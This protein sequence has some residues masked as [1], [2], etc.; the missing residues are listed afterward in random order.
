MIA[1]ARSYIHFTTPPASGH[2]DHQVLFWAVGS[3]NA[4]VVPYIASTD[5]AKTVI[6]ANSVSAD[7]IIL[8]PYSECEICVRPPQ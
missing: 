3:D 5:D 8:N 4:T 2:N 6:P 1:A 7:Y